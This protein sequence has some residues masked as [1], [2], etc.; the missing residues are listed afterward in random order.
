MENNSNI[1][2]PL[3]T[4]IT[5]TYN[6]AAYVRDAI[7]SVLSQTYENIEYIIGDDCSTDSTWKIVQEYKDPRIRAYRNEKN[8]GEYSNRNKAISEATGKYLIFVDGDDLIYPHGIGYFVS[9]MEKF[10]KA[11][12]AVQKGYTANVVYPIL[13]DSIEVLKNFYFGKFNLLTSSFA[14]NFFNTSILKSAGKLSEQYITA[15]EEIRLRLASQFPVLFVQGWVSWPRETPGQASSR[16]HDGSG[17]IESVRMTKGI[18]ESNAVEDDLIQ[19]EILNV[20]R[21]NAFY[22]MKRNV[23]SGKFQQAM[24]ILKQSGFRFSELIRSMAQ[25]PVVKDPLSQFDAGNPLKTK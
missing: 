24:R 14:S 4:V 16:I 6:S 13:L 2:K 3:V 9:Q 1:E 8:L 21:R 18:L 19:K 23:G 5:V 15:D 20:L 25:K 10:P 11:A 12:F 17:F 7:E 22:V